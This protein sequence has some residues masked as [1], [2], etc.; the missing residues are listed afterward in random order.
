MAIEVKDEWAPMPPNMG[1]PLPRS[2]QVY[3]PWYEPPEVPTE[4]PIYACPYCAA[5]FSTQTELYAHII[6]AHAGQPP[7][8]IYMCPHCGAQFDSL[9]A[10]Q[11]HMTRVHP[12]APPAVYTCAICG[13]TFATQA[14]LNY[15]MTTAHPQAPKDD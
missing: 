12:P 8:V 7:K 15:H 2:M 9:S 10:L 5:E 4:P 3:W 14:E 6:R 11:A 1:P 13:A